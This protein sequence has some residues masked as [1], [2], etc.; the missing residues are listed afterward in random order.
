MAKIVLTDDNG[1]ETVFTSET[2]L[3]TPVVA[4][5]APTVIEVDVKES[6]GSDVVAIPEAT[7]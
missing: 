4:P 3:P 6:D 2:L 7:A 1:V 5:I